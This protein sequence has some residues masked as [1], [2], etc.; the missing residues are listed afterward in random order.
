M[1][2]TISST[3]PQNHFSVLSLHIGSSI[4]I[5]TSKIQLWW[6]MNVKHSVCMCTCVQKVGEGRWISSLVYSYGLAVLCRCLLE[7]ANGE[8]RAN[9]TPLPPSFQATLVSQLQSLFLP[10]S[11]HPPV[12]TVKDD[13]STEIHLQLNQHIIICL[14]REKKEWERE[15][16]HFIVVATVTELFPICTGTTFA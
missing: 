12:P 3:N 1:A 16:F 14:T 9:F 8:G 11:P 6:V 2:L 10:S 15:N 5:T 13:K 7:G 4:L